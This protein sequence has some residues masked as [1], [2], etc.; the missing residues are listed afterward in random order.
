MFNVQYLKT[1][2]D[3]LL[4]NLLE[5]FQDPHHLHYLTAVIHNQ[6]KISL[7]ILDWFVTN[8]S[9]KYFVV[10]DLQDSRFKVYNDY[11]LK[12]KA[13]GKQRFDPFR[14]WERIEIP[15]PTELESTP[16]PPTP[17][18]PESTTES[19]VVSQIPL[20]WT[21]KLDTTIGQLNFFKWAI[22]NK[23]IDYIEAHFPAIEQ[24][25]N[26]RNS[27]SKKRAR[28]LH[29]SVAASAAVVATSDILDPSHIPENRV[30]SVAVPVLSS[31]SSI[32][33][34]N[35]TRKR[36]KELSE[37]ATKCIKKESVKV[38]VRFTN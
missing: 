7:R 10:Y 18:P 34:A 12:L 36:R 32:E 2:N 13:Y 23:I 29:A 33:L 8:Y 37:S 14:R 20:S 5:Y 22:E 6:T 30:L 31:S 25:M 17:I 38:I 16:N 35:K 11:K 28:S 26:Q 1:Q 3:V 4:Q 9:K 27:T 21:G 24:D 19:T 15:A